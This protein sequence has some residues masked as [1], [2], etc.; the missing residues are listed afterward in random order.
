MTIALRALA[1]LLA[2]VI[3]AVPAS[4]QTGARAGQWPY[5]GGDSGNTK[6]SPLDQ[7]NRD[8]VKG[9]KIAWRWKTDNFGPA[10]E[11]VYEPT[12]LM[13]NGVLY[14]TA[15]HRRAVV[16]LDPATGETLWFYRLDE[17]QRGLNAPRRNSGRGVSY[18]TDG[19][20]GR[21]FL[22]TPGYHLVALDARTGQPAAGFGSNGIVDLKQELDRPVDP[23]ETNIGSSSPPVVV[24]DVVVVGAALLTGSAPKSKTNAPGFIRGYDV[25]TG[26]RLW[27]FHTIP[28]PGEFGNETW[29][30]DSWRYTGNAGAWTNLA[31]DQ[32]LGY[33]YLPVEDATGDY[34]GGHRLGNNL[35]SSSIVCLDAKTGRR[36]WHYQLIHHDIWDYDPATGPILLDVTAGG[37][38]R[39]LVVQLTKQAFAYVFD[40]VTGEPIWPIEERPVRQTD[41]PG[42]R[43]SPTQPF[44][45]K[46]APFDLQGITVDN[47]IDF[48]PELRAEAMRIVSQYRI[49]PLYTPPS[50]GENPDG[51][52]GTIQIPGSGGGAN[53]DSGAVDLETGIL[54][55]ASQSSQDLWPLAPSPNSDMNFVGRRTEVEGPQG[56]PLIK[57]PWG[58]IT[59]IDLKTGDHLWMVP[60]GDTPDEVK[61]HPALRG[62]DIPNTG[63]SLRGGTLVTKTL[64]FAAA[65]EPNQL[66]GEPLLR[67]YDKR[68][69]ARI[70]T[71]DLPAVATGVP[72]T[73]LHNGKQYIVVAVGGKNHPGELVALTLP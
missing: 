23:V 3:S 69:G 8:N 52:K 35:F 27:I 63:K 33:V 60:N 65:A 59:A 71:I 7:I 26:K 48:T 31:A 54:Y 39:K 44:P 49:G 55:V 62:R 34:Y 5:F 9:L 29:E 21:I 66:Y 32:E 47:L 53:W 10:P 2:A 70:A 57:P 38:A 24:G 28:Q 61:N 6:Y 56:L 14:T 45:T 64:L 16:A 13:V 30:G 50:R 4:A 43:T 72:M 17:G 51:T 18:W 12:P 46:P 22:V 58:R 11:F 1:V 37:R 15:G 25:R 20:R 67:A 68:T 73:Y 19:T 41:V 40:R 36:V 42:D